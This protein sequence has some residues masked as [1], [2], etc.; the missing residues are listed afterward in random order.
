MENF[1]STRR[2]LLTSLDNEEIARREEGYIRVLRKLKPEY[3]ELLGYFASTLLEKDVYN[4]YQNNPDKRGAL[5]TE[6][7]SMGID[8]QGVGIVMKYFNFPIVEDKK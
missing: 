5:Q 6:L 1:E 7:S 8:N 2:P 4:S 3:Q